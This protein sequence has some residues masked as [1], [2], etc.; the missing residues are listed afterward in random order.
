ML[1]RLALVPAWCHPCRRLEVWPGAA[2]C[3]HAVLDSTASKQCQLSH[4][5]LSG[6]QTQTF[7]SLSHP[8]SC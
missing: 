3:L 8:S 7:P 5:N 2:C 1:V 6:R 4:A